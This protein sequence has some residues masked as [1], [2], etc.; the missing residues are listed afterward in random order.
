LRNFVEA[1]L[2]SANPRSNTTPNV[3]LYM[4][5]FRLFAT[6]NRYTGVS[7]CLAIT[8]TSQTSASFSVRPSFDA[9]I[10][11]QPMLRASIRL[12]DNVRSFMHSSKL[13]FS[14]INPV[15]FGQRAF[16][17]T[18]SFFLRRV[19]VVASLS[20]HFIRSKS[21]ETQLQDVPEIYPELYPSKLEQTFSS[22]VHPSIRI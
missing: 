21:N 18:Q 12:H 20:L 10:F 8:F 5:W 19:T 13:V 11:N 4:I 1:F 16:R 7:T 3:T 17:I 9:I 15:L 6:G 22:C 2:L 14:C